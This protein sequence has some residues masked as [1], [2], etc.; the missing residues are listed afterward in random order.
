MSLG[1]EGRNGALDAD[2]AA[3]WAHV[4][5]QV[6]PLKRKKIAKRAVPAK[7]EK[8]V[9]SSSSRATPSVSEALRPATARLP[10]APGARE[11]LPRGDERSLRRGEIAIDG[12]LDLHG[13]TRDEAHRAVKRFLAA[14]ATQDRKSTRLN[15]SH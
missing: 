1:R 14:M 4:T 6:R 7:G 5:A 11:K 10:L 8:N 3:L 2:D 12:R 15:S 13:L 9:K